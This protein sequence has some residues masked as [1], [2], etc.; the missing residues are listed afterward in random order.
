MSHLENEVSAVRSSHR[1][2]LETVSKEKAELAREKAELKRKEAE[3]ERERALLLSEKRVL[4][5]EKSELE[6]KKVALTRELQTEKSQLENEEAA[7]NC[8]H[9]PEVTNKVTTLCTSVG[10]PP[11]VS[12]KVSLLM[13]DVCMYVCV[14]TYA[15]G[16]FN[17]SQVCECCRCNME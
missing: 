14:H 9:Q 5:R 1:I 3:L 7:V 16:H 4:A 2:E 10:L 11:D 13:C 17:Y 12:Y 6:S 8:S 15:C